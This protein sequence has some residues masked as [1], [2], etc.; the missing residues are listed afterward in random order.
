MKPPNFYAKASNASILDFPIKIA[1]SNKNSHS[2]FHKVFAHVCKILT[3]FYVETKVKELISCS[4]QVKTTTVKIQIYRET[5]KYETLNRIMHLVNYDRLLYHSN[6]TKSF[7]QNSCHSCK[8]IKNKVGNTV[9]HT[10]FRASPSQAISITLA[11]PTE[12]FQTF[13]MHN[14]FT[15]RRRPRG[16]WVVSG[17]FLR[18]L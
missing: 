3:S 14:T 18:S 7:L 8:H 16:Q 4:Y 10:S 17:G 15:F 9:A 2:L 12:R 6:Y 13:Y 1:L 5:L 11:L